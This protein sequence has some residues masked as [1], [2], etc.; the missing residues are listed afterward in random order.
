M[1][2]RRAARAIG[3]EGHA[4]EVGNPANLCVHEATR[5]V[6]LLAEHARPRMVVGAGRLLATSGSTTSL[7]G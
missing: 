5:V 2:T 1:V 4:I 3:V 6:D 7:H